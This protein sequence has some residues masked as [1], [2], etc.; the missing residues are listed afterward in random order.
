MSGVGKDTVARAVR[1]A[2]RSVWPSAAFGSFITGP[3]PLIGITGAQIQESAPARI[4]RADGSDTRGPAGI[5]RHGLGQAASAV[6][7]SPMAFDGA[8]KTKR[9][10]AHFPRR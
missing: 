10:T 8:Y 6:H 7:Q 9:A 2:C 1:A 5:W 4:A 3:D